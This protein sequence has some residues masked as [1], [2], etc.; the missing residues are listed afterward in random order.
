MK[1][2]TVLVFVLSVVQ[3]R[4]LFAQAKQDSITTGSLTIVVQGLRSDKGTVQIG[5]FNS[6]ETWKSGKAKFRGAKVGINGGKAIWVVEDIPYGIYA[7]RL[8]HDENGND[9]LDANLFGMPSEDYGF[10][11]NAKGMFG[12]PGFDKAKFSFDEGHNEIIITIS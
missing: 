3:P 4:V 10:S 7:V 1:I 5:L 6:E 8:F 9:K 2:F 11:N 12:P